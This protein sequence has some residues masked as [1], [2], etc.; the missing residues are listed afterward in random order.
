VSSIDKKS[1][2]VTTV[3]DFNVKFAEDPFVK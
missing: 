3:M 2:K 1:V